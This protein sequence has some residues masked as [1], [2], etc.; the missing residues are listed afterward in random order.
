MEAQGAHFAIFI[1]QELQ[2]ILI[3]MFL[4][5]HRLAMALGK[6]QIS[7]SSDGLSIVFS[8]LTTI[9]INPLSV[10]RQLQLTDVVGAEIESV[11][12]TSVIGTKGKVQS[13]GCEVH[14]ALT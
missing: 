9:N 11:W 14:W 13:A 3:I 12:N 7:M 10:N 2:V 4:Y 8:R 5:V 1:I 6:A